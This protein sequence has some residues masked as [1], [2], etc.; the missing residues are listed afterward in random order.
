V[1]YGR[2]A[3]KDGHMVVALHVGNFWRKFC[4]A[5]GR[6]DLTDDPKFRTT[7]DRQ[8]NRVELEG[9]ICG[10]LLTKTAE[11]WHTLF[12]EAD[13]PH[14][15]VN[16]VGEALNQQVVK[17]RGLVK[18][19]SHPVA[20]AVRVVGSPLQFDLFPDIPYDAAPV[21]GEHTR[22]VLGGLLGYAEDRAAAL[23]EAGVIGLGSRDGQA[24]SGHDRTER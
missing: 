4:H 22:A 20:G 9:I 12:D 18:E 2:F 7:A 6:D 17:E 10:I 15:N 24:G 14:A 19:T 5:I 11:E 3:V 21:L 23:A 16:S 1:P 8:R 13:V